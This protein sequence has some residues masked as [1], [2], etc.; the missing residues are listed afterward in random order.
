[1]SKYLKY[2]KTVLQKPGL[3]GYTIIKLGISAFIYSY[4]NNSYKMS[5]SI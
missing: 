4:F 3:A 1:M 2:L 5:K